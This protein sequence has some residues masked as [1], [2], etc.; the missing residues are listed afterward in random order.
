MFRQGLSLLLFLALILFAVP[1]SAQD[2]EEGTEEEMEEVEEEAEEEPEEYEEE[3][4]E[5]DESGIDASAEESKDQPEEAAPA[6]EEHSRC[7]LLLLP[8]TASY[9]EHVYVSNT[10][11]RHVASLDGSFIVMQKEFDMLN[12]SQEELQSR[13]ESLKP[14]FESGDVAAVIG[15]GQELLPLLSKNAG[16][17]GKNRSASLHGTDAA[18]NRIR[19]T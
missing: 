5:E 15:I 1:M 19:G 14:L 2:E 4:E 11:S 8:F 7:V 16:L 18:G 9:A 10:V 17:I 6:A 13:F 3:E 12:A